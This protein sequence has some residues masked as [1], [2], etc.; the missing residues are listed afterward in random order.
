MKATIF[1][2]SVHFLSFFFLLGAGLLSFFLILSG[3]RHTGTLTHF[4]WFQANTEGFNDASRITRWYNYDFCG[5]ENGDLTNCSS[6]APAKPFSPRDNF[7]RSSNMPKT[8]LDNRN[9]YYYLSR[10][11]WAMLLIALFFLALAFIPLCITIFKTITGVAVFSTVTCWI[12]L[13]FMTLAAC[14]YTGCYVKARQAFHRN[15]RSAKLGAKNFGFIWTTVFLLLC[16]SIWATYTIVHHK[17]KNQRYGSYDD[18]DVYGNYQTSG[19]TTQLDK[20]YGTNDDEQAGLEQD[21]N[22]NTVN[23]TVIAAETTTTNTAAVP[24]G[25]Q[26]KQY[27][28]KLRNKKQDDVSGNTNT[29]VIAEEVR[30]EV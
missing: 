8:F 23:D 17:K 7:G 3:G 5:L 30:Q 13:F 6:K 4:Y 19:E 24:V 14:L 15:N 11:A 10:V 16:N 27:F 9:A 2:K 18:Q 12:A 1:H 21:P 28:T 20:S 29:E 25:T 26:N 22:I